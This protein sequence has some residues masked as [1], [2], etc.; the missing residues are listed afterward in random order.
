M[1]G[2]AS[3]RGTWLMSVWMWAWTLSFDADTCDGDT[4]VAGA[5]TLPWPTAVDDGDGRRRAWCCCC[6]C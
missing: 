1:N 5:T 2:A 6:C 3:A 4:G